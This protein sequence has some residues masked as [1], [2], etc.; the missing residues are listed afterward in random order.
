MPQRPRRLSSGPI[1]SQWC[2]GTESVRAHIVRAL[3]EGKLAT[4]T[5]RCTRAEGSFMSDLATES[6][7][8][9]TDLDVVGSVDYLVVEFPAAKSTSRARWRTSCSRWS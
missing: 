7:E 5:G 6:V 4:Y 9:E 1:S 8:R 2:D 3:V